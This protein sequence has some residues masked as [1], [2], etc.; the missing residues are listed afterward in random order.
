MSPMLLNQLYEETALIKLL[1]STDRPGLG[2]G[3]ISNYEKMTKS[4]PFFCGNK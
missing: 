2:E 1:I 4:S 3:G